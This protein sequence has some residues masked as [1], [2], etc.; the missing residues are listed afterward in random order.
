ME[1]TVTQIHYLAIATDKRLGDF[2]TDAGK[3]W[4]K[5]LDLLEALPSFRRLYW[6]RSPEDETRVQLHVG[7]SN[8][9]L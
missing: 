1:S 8:F 9:E 2:N 5:A 3:T 7:K 4:S 6:G